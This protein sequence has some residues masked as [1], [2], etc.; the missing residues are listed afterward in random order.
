MGSDSDMDTGSEMGS[1]VST[2]DTDSD[3]EDDTILSVQPSDIYIS[4]PH[5]N[6]HRNASRSP[7]KFPITSQMA[8][9]LARLK[10]KEYVHT[11]R[12]MVRRFQPGSSTVWY[13]DGFDCRKSTLPVWSRCASQGSAYKKSKA[14]QVE[15]SWRRAFL[16][17][18][19]FFFGGRI[20][21]HL[22]VVEDPLQPLE[23]HV[24]VVLSCCRS[25]WGQLPV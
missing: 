13:A 14:E 22:F 20:T 24:S 18:S 8:A 17:P 21:C 25:E 23:G 4:N 3:M 19:V 15:D 5:R 9:G 1:L 12:M 10:F 16:A 6:T 11:E 2:E 7:F